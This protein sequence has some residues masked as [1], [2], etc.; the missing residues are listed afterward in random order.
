MDLVC[1]LVSVVYTVQY[2][3]RPPY[4]WLDHRTK[5]VRP[6]IIFEPFQMINLVVVVAVIDLTK[7]KVF[8]F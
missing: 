1:T 3:P 2:T 5:C 6:N 4:G 7:E 8:S